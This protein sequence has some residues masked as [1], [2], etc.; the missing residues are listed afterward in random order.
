MTFHQTAPKPRLSWGER[1]EEF[2]F[3]HLTSNRLIYN[4]S[5]EDP[6]VDLRTMRL[7]ES[8]RVLVITSAGCNVLDYALEQPA[9]VI[10]VDA[11]PCQT[12]LL[13]LKLAG[14]RHLDHDD[15]FSIFGLGWHPDFR[16]LY[17]R[18][19][20]DLSEFAKRYWDR[21]AHW[22]SGPETNLFRRGL[23]GAV[24]RFFQWRMRIEPNL[25]KHVFA[26][27][28]QTDIEAQRRIYVN[29]VQPRF[30]TRFMR[31]FV[32]SPMVLSMVG[33]PMPQRRLMNAN[34]PGNVSGSIQAMIDNLFCTVP[35]NDNYFWGVYIFGHYER[36]R[37]PRYLTREGFAK[38]KAGLVD[39]I[40]AHTCTVTQYL[41]QPGPK[42]THAVLLD[43]M[44][45]MSSYYP[46]DLEAEWTAL[47]ERVEPGGSV[48]FRSAHMSPPFL[49][50]TLI[51]AERTPIR[52]LLTFREG[53]AKALSRAD[54]VHTYASFHIAQ[55]PGAT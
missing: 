25:R 15:M 30:W 51:G 27:F 7:K 31:W 49:D 5:W 50:K 43:H 47:L 14:I 6:A 17:Q 16:A 33:V 18:M 12:A 45:W 29:E 20:G 36:T 53:E 46:A 22:F 11:N 21:R 13:E 8:D 55:T 28:D 24:V 4:T 23:T 1:F 54:R 42:L 35:A 44:D 3:R 41:Q 10:A 9:C 48:L 32:A 52:Q 34:D 2:S 37:C 38:L 39:R 19:R 26:M 40:E